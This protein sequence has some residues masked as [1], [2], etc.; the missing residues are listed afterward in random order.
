MLALL[1]RVQATTAVSGSYTLTL[2]P[3]VSVNGSVDVLPLH[4]TFSPQMQFAVNQLEVQ[5]AAPA[6]GSAIA[7]QASTAH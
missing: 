5:P 7:G 1:R 3:H 2:I 4:A 6:G